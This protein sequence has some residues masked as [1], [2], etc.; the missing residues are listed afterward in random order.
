M[1][2]M[3]ALFNKRRGRSV[4]GKSRASRSRRGTE[5]YEARVLRAKEICLLDV[6]YFLSG[7]LHG[8]IPQISFAY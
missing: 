1:R 6:V 2:V 3:F 7:T 5:L 4:D 8:L